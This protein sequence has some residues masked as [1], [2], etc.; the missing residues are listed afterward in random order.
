MLAFVVGGPGQPVSPEQ[1]HTVATWSFAFPWK[2]ILTQQSTGKI[3]IWRLNV[4]FE[5]SFQNS[6]PEERLASP[7]WRPTSSTKVSKYWCFNT[8]LPGSKG[9][10]HAVSVFDSPSSQTENWRHLA[11]T[12]MPVKRRGRKS[13]NVEVWGLSGL[14]WIALRRPWRKRKTILFEVEEKGW[15]IQVEHLLWAG[16]FSKATGFPTPDKMCGW[17][18]VPGKSVVTLHTLS[19]VVGV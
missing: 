2:V 11:P 13:W 6:M 5:P 18:T 10:H 1:A 14:A 3:K 7:C 17:Q 15:V 4:A 19:W 9:S 16:S 8:V 12:F